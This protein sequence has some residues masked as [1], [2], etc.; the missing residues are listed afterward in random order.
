MLAQRLGKG[1]T[2]KWNVSVDSLLLM[3]CHCGV[4]GDSDLQWTEVMNMEGSERDG[5]FLWYTKHMPGEF[6][7]ARLM[8][9]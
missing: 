2:C 1:D 5:R 8:G 3:W 7:F 4:I 6:R 9:E